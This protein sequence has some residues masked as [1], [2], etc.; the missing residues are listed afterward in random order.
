LSSESSESSGVL[1]DIDSTLL[2]EVVH[3]EIDKFVIEIFSTEMGVTVGGLDLEDTF[4]NG[5]EGNI[6]SST[7]EIEDEDVL[8]LLLLSVESVGNS[9]GG[10]LVDDSKNV[11]SGDGSGILGSLSL[12]V[13]EI[14]WDSDDG[15]LD[16]L[17]EVCFGDCLHLLEN[18]G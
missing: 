10:W 15:G 2:L 16:F 5:E 1:G 4:F 12:G 14:S 17:S 6:E 9:S 7:T 18:H 13:V 8:L 3:A 11:D